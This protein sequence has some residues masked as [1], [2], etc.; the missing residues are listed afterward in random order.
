MRVKKRAELIIVLSRKTLKLHASIVYLSNFLTPLSTYSQ[1]TL[2]W[3]TF[4]CKKSTRAL[5][6]L[7]LYLSPFQTADNMIQQIYSIYTQNTSVL[8]L[9]YTFN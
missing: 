1:T 6:P 8:I 5:P 4:R 9:T 3:T 2:T 7:T